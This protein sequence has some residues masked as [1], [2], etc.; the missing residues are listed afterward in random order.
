MIQDYDFDESKAVPLKFQER[1]LRQYFREM[2]VNEAGLRHRP[3]AA[4]LTIF[5]MSIQILETVEDESSDRDEWFWFDALKTDYATDYW[6][7]HFLEIDVDEVSDADAKSV[8]E[9]LYTIFKP[10]GEALKF[11]EENSIG[12]IFGDSTDA[13]DSFF[14]AMNSWSLRASKLAPDILNNDIRTFIEE[15][16]VSKDKLLL[17]LARC[18]ISNWFRG[19]ESRGALYAFDHA[20]FAF[21]T[22]VSSG[23]YQLFPPLRQL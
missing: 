8:I 4:H 2:D 20:M 11:L 17:H 13:Q 14:K 1:S 19:T 7:H 22:M 9:S 21:D 16:S 23:I 12:R 3:Q 5:L 6:I 18:H 10:K 15:A